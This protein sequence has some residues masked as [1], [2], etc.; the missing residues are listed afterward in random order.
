M[1]ALTPAELIQMHHFREQVFYRW[2]KPEIERQPDSAWQVREEGYLPIQLH[3]RPK[4]RRRT[5][6]NFLITIGD[7]N[8]EDT[9]FVEAGHEIDGHG[10]VYFFRNPEHADNFVRFRK[11]QFARECA[12]LRPAIMQNLDRTLNSVSESFWRGVGDRGE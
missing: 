11:E 1:K 4:G 10:H 6:A 8:F 5:C 2:F 12:S 3:E 9:Q 7:F